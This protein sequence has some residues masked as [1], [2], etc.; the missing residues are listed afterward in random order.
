MQN[1][2]SDAAMNFLPAEL[3]HDKQLSISNE[4]RMDFVIKAYCIDYASALLGVLSAI[5]WGWSA[6]VAIPTGYD[7]DEALLHK[8]AIGQGIPN[9]K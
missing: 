2:P 9:P 8:S 5:F 1:K 4:G 6:K 7:T 3:R